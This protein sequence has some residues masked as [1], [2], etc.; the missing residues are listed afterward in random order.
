MLQYTSF[1]I[2]KKKKKI[3]GVLGVGGCY[4]AP[5]VGELRGSLARALLWAAFQHLHNKEITSEKDQGPSL[6]MEFFT[7][8]SFIHSC[9][10]LAQT[11]WVS[12]MFRHRPRTC[13]LTT[14]RTELLCWWGEADDKHTS[15]WYQL[16]ML[17]RAGSCRMLEMVSLHRWHLQRCDLVSNQ[18][19]SRGIKS[20]YIL[21]CP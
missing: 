7:V 15:K 6:L 20:V 19:E 8:K 5:V 17:R 2:K 1:S 18:N 16:R 11:N 4:S 21:M 12:G 9:S 3:P 14:E 10:H 13:D